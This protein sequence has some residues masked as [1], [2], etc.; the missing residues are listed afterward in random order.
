MAF[1]CCCRASCPA[2][3]LKSTEQD[4]IDELRDVFFYRERNTATSLIGYFKTR[5]MLTMKLWAPVNLLTS[6]GLKREQMKIWR[7][8]Q[9][10]GI[11]ED[12]SADPWF[13]SVGLGAVLP[14]LPI[15]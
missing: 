12:Q 15:A 11:A 5:G 1:G 9:V 4:V 7:A 10:S 8:C 14:E 2:F 13:C 6:Y 3:S